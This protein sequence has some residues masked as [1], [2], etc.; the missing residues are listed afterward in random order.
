MT[1]F[2]KNN[3]PKD[4]QPWAREVTKYLSSL[5]QS[6]KADQ[7]NNSARDN[8]LNSSLIALTGV[9]SGLKQVQGEITGV[10]TDI[11][12]LESTVLVPGEPDKINGANI[13]VGTLSASQITTGTLNASVV[14]VTNINASNITA[15]TIT[16]I[17][18]R[19]RSSGARISLTATRQSFFDDF[20]SEAGFIEVDGAQYRNGLTLSSSGSTLILSSGQA[21][22]AGGGNSIRANNAGVQAFGTFNG[23]GRVESGGNMRSGGTLGRVE[24]DGGGTTGASINNAGNVIRTA[25]SERY[26]QDIGELVINYED[27]L[28]LSPKKFRLKEEVIGSEEI[29]ANKNARYYA[30]FIAEEIAETPLDIFVSYEKLEDG[31]SRPDGVYYAELT[32]ALLAGIK[33]QD[34]LIKSLNDRIETLE[35]GA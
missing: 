21:E 29:E 5:I 32:A 6:S 31:T 16:G 33:H 34:T 1:T 24:L 20:G 3:L 19:T 13:K 8:Q 4:A 27:L 30:G 15:G 22:I 7:I 2:P 14:N 11:G 12:L 35:K 10:L 25:S 9:V 26:K 28:L 18:F 23:S 17:T